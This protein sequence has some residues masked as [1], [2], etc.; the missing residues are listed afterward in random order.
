[1]LLYHFKTLTAP[2]NIVIGDHKEYNEFGNIVHVTDY[3][4]N[5]RSTPE[6]LVQF[7]K[8]KG[9]A[10]HHPQTIIDRDHTGNKKEWYVEFLS[11]TSNKI[12]MYHLEDGTL[13][14]LKQ[15]FRD[16]NFLKD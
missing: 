16:E 11:T 14:V 13:K 10:F 7:I 3:D 8:A 4:K 1:M 15:T 12:E 2:P 9:G 6:D 5:Y